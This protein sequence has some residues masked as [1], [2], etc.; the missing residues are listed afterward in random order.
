MWFT[1]NFSLTLSILLQKSWFWNKSADKKKIYK[2]PT[3]I[4]K[5]MGKKGVLLYF[6]PYSYQKKK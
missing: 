5:G 1:G 2:A 4:G 3:L 6:C